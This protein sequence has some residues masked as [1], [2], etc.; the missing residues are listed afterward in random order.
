MMLPAYVIHLESAKARRA[1][2][3]ALCRSL[4]PEARIVPAVDGARLRRSARGQPSDPR[5][6]PPYPF[7]L[8]SAEEAAFLSHRACWQRLLDEGHE[9]ALIVEDDIALGSDFAGAVA[10]AAANLTERA[11][12][13]F[14]LRRQERP[15]RVIASAG[16]L[17]LYRP[18]VVGLGMQA[19]IVT[20]GA[21]RRL[22]ATSRRFDRPV[23]AFLQLTWLHRADVL[24][25]WRSGI[26]E[27]SE[28]LG[29]STI[30]RR[31]GGIERLRRE[32]LRPLYRFAVALQSHL[33]RHDP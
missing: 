26:G 7:S 11:F 29:G 28:T 9:A 2:A 30:H 25:V 24:S 23:D 17:Q 20:S 31:P 5:P 18:R 3:D 1:H 4:G 15:R 10:L 16:A 32:A 19:Q 33:L 27:V 13:R 12:V 6:F 21:A 14:P 22:L 8:R